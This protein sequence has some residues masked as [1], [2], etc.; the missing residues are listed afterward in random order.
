M[1]ISEWAKEEVR[2]ACEREAP[3]RDRGEWGYG[4]SCYESALK[5]YL[6]LMDDEHSGYSFSITAG[7][8]K[9]L[10]EG[11]ALTPI[12][13]VP[14]IWHDVTAIHDDVRTF[15]C[16]RMSSLF[17]DIHPDGSVTYHDVGRCV[18]KDK[19]GLTFSSGLASRLIDELYPIT[20]PYY[21]PLGRYEMSCIEWLTD[22]KNGDFDTIGFY[23]IKRP[24]GCVDVINRYYAEVD[25]KWETITR[26]EYEIR[27]HRHCVRER[28]EAKE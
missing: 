2:I 13:D 18:C 27:M 5:A 15:Q 22:R 20:M 9:R 28:L 26:E 24:D 16:K 17:K 19:D 21:P 1:S 10:L 12:V 4:C 3:C 11:K 8:L 23:E 25:G 7:I 6:S 14:E